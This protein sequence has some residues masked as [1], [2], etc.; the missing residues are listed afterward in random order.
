MNDFAHNLIVDKVVDM[1]L[2]TQT[3]LQSC[4][5]LDRAM[6]EA[7]RAYTN[8]V[9]LSLMDSDTL[10][11]LG[12][13]SMASQPLFSRVVSAFM[14]I[15]PT[16]N[17]LDKRATALFDKRSTLFNERKAL[18]QYRDRVIS[19]DMDLSRLK[20]LDVYFFEYRP[21]VGYISTLNRSIVENDKHMKKITTAQN[22][23]NVMDAHLSGVTSNDIESEYMLA[24]G[25]KQFKPT[26]VKFFEQNS[27]DDL[28]FV[29]DQLIKSCLGM[30][31]MLTHSTAFKSTV[32]DLKARPNM[33]KS[34]V[35]KTDAILQLSKDI[36]DKSVKCC[37]I[38]NNVALLL[39]VNE[40]LI[41]LT[42]D[43]WENVFGVLGE[44]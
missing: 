35:G 27:L 14:S 29:T 37:R 41:T 16:I 17:D 30:E 15:L 18:E 34:L 28:A 2:T 10:A 26:I 43:V 44:K 32:N 8:V 9:K 4:S 25:V 12:Y 21:L 11:T 13:E 22:L 5:N 38:V 20:D 42:R 19:E 40:S 39:K 7:A 36:S 1:V 31:A 24:E 6:N 3:E 33:V 23:S